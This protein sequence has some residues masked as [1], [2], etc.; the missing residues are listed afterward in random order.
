[1]DDLEIVLVMKYSESWAPRGSIINKDEQF[2][3]HGGISQMEVAHHCFFES[4]MGAHKPSVMAN[5]YLFLPKEVK[6]VKNQSDMPHY[7][8]LWANSF[9]FSGESLLSVETPR[10]L[11]TSIVHAILGNYKTYSIIHEC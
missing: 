8:V 6:A 7:R 1:M 2:K 5:N 4:C 9:R 10:T 3:G 11:I